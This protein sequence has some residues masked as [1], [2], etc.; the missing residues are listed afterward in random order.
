[1]GCYG[2][3]TEGQKHFAIG[4]FLGILGTVFAA[5]AATALYRTGQDDIWEKAVKAGVAVELAD[6]EYE[7]KKGGE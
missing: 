6:D 3:E 2:D 5:V 4:I 1:M 7:F